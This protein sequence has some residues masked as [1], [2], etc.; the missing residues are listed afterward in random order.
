MRLNRGDRAHI[1]VERGGKTH[2]TDPMVVHEVGMARV[3]EEGGVMAS[4]NLVV[5][6]GEYMVVILRPPK[7]LPMEVSE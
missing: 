6:P 5:P 4:V 1:V 2:R 7:V 3:P